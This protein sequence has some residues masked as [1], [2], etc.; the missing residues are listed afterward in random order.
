MSVLQ[1]VAV[2]CVVVCRGVLQCACTPTMRAVRTCSNTGLVEVNLYRCAA[3]C[4]S[5]LCYSMSQCVAVCC[6]AVHEFVYVSVAICVG[7]LA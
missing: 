2:C 1:C 7:A 4:C 3:V 6:V 5:V